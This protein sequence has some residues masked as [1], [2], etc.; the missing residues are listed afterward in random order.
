MIQTSSY[1]GPIPEDRE[2]N[3]ML[4]NV[5]KNVFLHTN[6]AFLGSLL[7]SHDFSW[8]EPADPMET[9]ATDGLTIWW[10]KADFMRCAQTV[11]GVVQRIQMSER[12]ATLLHE[13]DHTGF[14]HGLRRGDRDPRIWNVACD[15]MINLL[16]IKNG[17]KL[18]QN[19]WWVFDHQYDGWAE[20]D[21]Y[22]DLVKHPA[23]MPKK[24]RL[25]LKI[26]QKNGP[27]AKN[28]I[29]AVVVRAVQAAEMAGQAGD[30]PGNLKTVLNKFLEPK[31][32]WKSV[33][34]R[35]MTDLVDEGDY[36]WR[37][38]SRRFET[39]MPSIQPEEGKLDDE[40]VF[41]EDT[42]G[43]ISQKN[44]IRMNSEVKFIKETL[45]PEKFTLLQFDTKIQYEKVFTKDEPFENIESHGYGGTNLTEVRKWLQK[46]KPKAAIIFSDLECAQMEPLTVPTSVIWIKVRENGCMPKF[47]IT[48]TMSED[49]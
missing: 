26:D 20:E 25:D 28:D 39:Y 13:L 11:V 2:L 4:E 17:Y 24:V 7:C 16:L 19:G 37:R 5:K 47:G 27:N 15:H 38:P 12:E 21:I 31:I 30:L 32:N 9:A 46:R 10:N 44:R 8:V 6:A 45:Q 35:W 49:E 43:S 33:L 41:I 3:K 40:L 36:S 18:P 48:V 23:K 29:L 14:M 34:N 22:D 1:T 42:S